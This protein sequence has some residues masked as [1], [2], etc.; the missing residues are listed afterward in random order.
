M[1]LN[2]TVEKLVNLWNHQYMFISLKFINFPRKILNIHSFT[3]RG[4][5][6]TLL[7]FMKKFGNL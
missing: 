7:N 4:I 6:K 5:L 1:L 2:V 3:L